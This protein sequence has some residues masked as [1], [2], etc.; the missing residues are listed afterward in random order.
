MPVPIN[1][2]E[3]GSRRSLLERQDSSLRMGEPKS[4]QTRSNINAHQRGHA[5]GIFD[6]CCFAPKPG[7]RI[8]RKM[9]TAYV[10]EVAQT[11]E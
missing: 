10:H 6:R 4:A 3:T 8:V 7:T 5:L 9:E 1:W 2:L 11:S